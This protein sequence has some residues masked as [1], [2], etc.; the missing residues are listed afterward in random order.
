MVTRD[1]S[2]VCNLHH[3]SRQRWIPHPL[4]E[5]RDRT[6]NLMAPSQIRF[7]C[8]TMG[9]PTGVF[10]VP[11]NTCHM[12]EDKRD[13][14]ERASMSRAFPQKRRGTPGGTSPC[15]VGASPQ[16]TQDASLLAAQGKSDQLA[17]QETEAWGSG[18]LPQV[19][20]SSAGLVS[21]TEVNSSLQCREHLEF[22]AI[23]LS[24]QKL[25]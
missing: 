24:H 19:P 21:L 11:S 2:H 9:T 18:A 8:T 4:S 25:W 20:A 6:R 14:L 1:T 5:A 15:Q 7:S 3:S 16:G 22:L 12:E 23:C 10:L 13:L 17:E